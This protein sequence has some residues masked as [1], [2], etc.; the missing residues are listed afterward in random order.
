MTET[1][2]PA[3]TKFDFEKFA[4]ISAFK[5][6]SA[7]LES[8]SRIGH[9]VEDFRL[10]MAKLAPSLIHA[11]G[12]VL[13]DIAKADAALKAG[14]VP[15]PGLPIDQ[16]EA[17]TPIEE[18]SALLEQT[19]LDT[20][21]FIREQ[22]GQSVAASG[23]DSEAVATFEEALQ[24]HEAGLYRSVVRVLFPEI[25]RVARESV[26]EGERR[27][28]PVGRK[29]KGTLNAGLKDFREAVMTQLPAGV[30]TE[31][32]FGLSL[33]D[34]MYEHLYKWVGE[35]EASLEAFR[36]DP[37]P[38]RHASQ[39]GYVIYASRQNSL[40]TLAMTDFMFHLLMRT[41]RYIAEQTADNGAGD[42]HT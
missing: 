18:I 26:Y 6:D 7:L 12:T 21:P 31:S 14:W 36:R 24:A 33:A 30:V 28:A 11:F 41:N 42:D 9:A 37:V 4:K 20:W 39:H 35:D 40:N 13:T 8:L 25:E 32:Q 38:N 19:T 2:L 17:D 5:I 16:F 3:T 23:V 22:L 34:K 1:K 15:F 29:N 27:E 10:R